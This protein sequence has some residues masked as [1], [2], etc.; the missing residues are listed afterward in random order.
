MHPPLRVEVPD[1]ALA[2]ALRTQLQQFDVDTVAVEGH[3]EVRV[4]LLKR[5]PESRVENALHAI[6]AWLLTAGIGSIRVQ[7]DGHSYLLDAPPQ[8][9]LPAT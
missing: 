8:S 6:D 7:L 2:A 1:E 5:N 3:W 4:N 9:G